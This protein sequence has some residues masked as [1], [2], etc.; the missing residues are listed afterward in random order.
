MHGHVIKRSEMVEM[1][2]GH[3]GVRGCRDVE[4]IQMVLKISEMRKCQNMRKCGF[5]CVE[6]VHTHHQQKTER[7]QQALKM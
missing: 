6:Q 3:F 4:G 1:C 5:T 2:A 7:E